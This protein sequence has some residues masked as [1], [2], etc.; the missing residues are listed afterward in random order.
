MS[1]GVAR[2][3]DVRMLDL[4]VTG[5]AADSAEAA[6]RFCT[7]GA[8]CIIVLGGDGTVRAVSKGAGDV[9]LLPISTGTNNVLP[10]FVEG[11]DRRAGGGGRGSWPGGA[12]QGGRAPQVAGGGREWPAG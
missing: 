10:S 8:R 11:T 3:P 7:A 6:R 12:G 4:P 1:H 5:Q 9:P 2:L